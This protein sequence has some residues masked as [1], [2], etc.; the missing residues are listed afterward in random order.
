MKTR[1]SEQGVLGRWPKPVKRRDRKGAIVVLTAFLLIF[2]MSLLA[3]SIDI[4]YIQNANVELDRAVDAGA[5]AGAGVLVQGEDLA[6]DAAREFATLNTVAGRPLSLS[7]LSVEV[8][9]WNRETRSFSPSSTLP[10]AIHLRAARDDVRPM[11]FGRVLGR[12]SFSVAA[13]AVAVYQ[14]RDIVLVLDYSGSMN[15]DSEFRSIE[16]LGR[17]SIENNL[18]LIHNQLGAPGYGS[19][20]FAPQ[21]MTVTG[22]APDNASQP[23]ITVEYRYET[24]VVKSTKPFDR[25]RVYR[26]ATSYQNFAGVG[27]WN[28]A[29]GVYEQT[30]TY[31]G[32]A[33]VTK[34]EVRSGYNDLPE[35]SAN[36]YTELFLFDTAARMRAHARASFGLDGVTYPYPGGSW[37]DYIDYCR[38]GTYNTQ[39]GYRYKFGLMNLVN[40]WL[41]RQP[42]YA[43]V[44]DL[45]KTSEQPITAVKNSVSVFISF[46]QEMDS[47]DQLALAVYNSPQATALVERQLGLDL[48]EVETIS[49]H[50]QAGHYHNTTNIG[51]GLREAWMELNANARPGAFKMIVL[52]TDGIANTPSSDPI[53]Y[54]MEQVAEC[55]ARGYPVVT[56]SL[57]AGADTDL[58][59]QVAELTGGT[60]FNVPGGQTV[61][62][63]EE[64]LKE[65][66][67]KIARK[68]P[69]QLVQ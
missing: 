17:E 60:H 10:Y 46:L 1:T 58:M 27:S 64:D 9:A 53:G 35:T 8:G 52:M 36:L 16:T 40:Y 14:P 6:I 67:R 18:R 66:F 2:I 32:S 3:F 20:E 44:P 51:A 42:S 11:F 34:V 28:A 4:G 30:L 43:A 29:E 49:R 21:W 31:N 13:E 7:E 47:D 69:L 48:D 38:S 39:A 19:L 15:D 12:D 63:Y 59:D 24:V 65:A 26:N 50:R 25:V 57:G 37:N 41:E 5:L 45:W 62:E 55:Q 22:H 54:V 68:R 61:A 33:Q 56:V 23:Q